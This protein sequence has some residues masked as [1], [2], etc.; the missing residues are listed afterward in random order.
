MYKLLVVDDE[1]IIVQR[2]QACIDWTSVEIDRIYTAYN[3]S[4]ALEQ[5]QNIKPDIIISDVCMPSL[6]GI[7]FLKSLREQNIDTQVIFISGFSEFK[8]VKEALDYGCTGYVTKPIDDEELLEVVKK[9]ISNI[10]LKQKQSESFQKLQD[11]LPYAQEHLWIHA[12]NGYFLNNGAFSSECEKLE[13]SYPSSRYMCV[14]IQIFFQDI[15]DES[16]KALLTTATVCDM[17]NFFRNDEISSFCFSPQSCEAV[18]FVFPE[19]DSDK[20]IVIKHI[21]EIILSIKEFSGCSA[22]Y[23]ISGIVDGWENIPTA[24]QNA[25]KAAI[26]NQGSLSVHL[27]NNSISSAQML[28]QNQIRRFCTFTAEQD[29]DSVRAEVSSV[30]SMLPD[31]ISNPQLRSF[32]FEFANA[33]SSQLLE[34][35]FIHD[36]ISSELSFILLEKLQVVDSKES[37]SNF[38]YELSEVL[39]SDIKMDSLSNSNHVI[40]EIIKYVDEHYSEPISSKTVADYFYFNPSYFSRLFRT[41][42]SIKFTSYLTNVRLEKAEEMMRTGNM[43]TSDIATAVGFND[44]RYFYKIYKQLRGITPKQYREKQ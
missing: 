24:Y 8:Y 9:G 10:K 42:M 41:N 40:Q 28:D 37:L 16:K 1:P 12:I 2:L 34:E 11:T 19:G 29:F 17:T 20:G 23:G 38:L 22:S 44:A 21:D 32:G 36:I 39:S 13:L 35:G 27:D 4:E 7:S 18:S 30:V 6:D 15:A 3:G 14:C 43:R 31:S 5:V 25:R 33:A 26:I